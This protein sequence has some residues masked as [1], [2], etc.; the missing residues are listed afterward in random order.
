MTTT[1]FRFLVILGVLFV[2]AVGFF[3]LPDLTFDFIDSL[4]TLVYVVVLGVVL[5]PFVSDFFH[6]SIQERSSK[7]VDEPTELTDR[8]RTEIDGG[9][10]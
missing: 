3:R 8:Q 7:T 1:V 9:D 5:W 4:Q 2:A 6:V 10:K